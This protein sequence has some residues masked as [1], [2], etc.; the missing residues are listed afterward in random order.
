MALIELQN[1]NEARRLQNNGYSRTGKKSVETDFKNLKQLVANLEDKINKVVIHRN[2]GDKEAEFLDYLINNHQEGYHK[3]IYKFKKSG[4]SVGRYD[5]RVCLIK[6]D[7]A[8]IHRNFKEIV[9]SPK[10]VFPKQKV[11]VNLRDEEYS[12]KN[13][14]EE[15]IEA[16]DEEISE[17]QDKKQEL[18]DKDREEWIEET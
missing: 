11:T 7:K 5:R 8:T 9:N 16:I 18:Q 4:T 17:L 14:K 3:E 13:K 6:E 2:N 10:E 12:F 1:N 15:V